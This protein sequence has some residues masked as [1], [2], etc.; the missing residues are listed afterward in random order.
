VTVSSSKRFMHPLEHRNRTCQV[1]PAHPR[2]RPP[3]ER[4]S[5]WRAEGKPNGVVARLTRVRQQTP[6]LRK[7]GPPL[8]SREGTDD[9]LSLASTRCDAVEHPLPGPA[10]RL[11][12]GAQWT[13]SGGPSVW[14]TS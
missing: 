2:L 11:K 12:A 5:C 13:G 6:L 4:E 9:Y 8:A 10:V 3:C 14:A 7:R 1:A